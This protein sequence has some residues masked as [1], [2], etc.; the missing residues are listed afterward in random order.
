MWIYVRSQYLRTYA[1]TY[2]RVE[3]WCMDILG[4]VLWTER[5]AEPKSIFSEYVFNNVRKD[6]CR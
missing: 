6:M 5:H 2:V 3:T 4:A 1:W